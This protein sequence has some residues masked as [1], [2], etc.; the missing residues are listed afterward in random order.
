MRVELVRAV[1]EDGVTLDGALAEPAWSL[2]NSTTTPSSGGLP[3][4]APAV[5]FDGVVMVHGVGGSFY[6]SPLLRGLAE[7]YVA[8]GV[9]TLRVNTRGHDS[10][11]LAGTKAGVRRQGAM[12]E[13][14]D[15]CRWD[16]ATWLDWAARRG[17]RRIVLWGHSLG[18]IKSVY[19]QAREPHPQ[20]AAIVAL[21][22]PR[23]SAAAYNAAGSLP[24]RA[25]LAAARREVE[26]GRPEAII[27]STFP[28]PM[29]ISAGAYLDKYGGETY[30][31][32]PLAH[33]LQ[34]PTLF[35]YGERELADGNV[36][37]AGLDQTLP[38]RARPDQRLDTAVIAGADHMYA[39][40]FEPAFERQL[41]WLASV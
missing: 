24:Y 36:A 20:V 22:P 18:A 9:P 3:P 37:F 10:M 1:A 29:P 40:R 4:A 15:E 16:L 39:G 30:S 41:T 11:F 31:I 6:T 5:A 21:S 26:A 27:D 13:I 25:S 2:V 7:R 8:A 19:S 28:Y 23:L 17:W 14:V 38:Q 35:L 32:E 12:F 34:A 33:L